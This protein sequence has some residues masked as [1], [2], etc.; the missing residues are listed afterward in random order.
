MFLHYIYKVFDRIVKHVVHDY[1]V[2]FVSMSEFF[3]G[4]A[5]AQILFLGALAPSGA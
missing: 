4:V 2:I 3:L 5:D 1:A